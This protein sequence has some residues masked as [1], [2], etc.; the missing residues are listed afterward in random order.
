MD[1]E[2]LG[3]AHVVGA[4]DPVDEL[5][6]GQHASGVAQQHLQEVEL[7]ERQVDLAAGD[8][9]HVPVD[10]HPHRAGLQGLRYG[11]L[12]FAPAAQHGADAGDQLA[13]GEGL[14][15]VVVGPYLQPDDLVD[16]AVL[17]GDHDHRHV[18]A[19]AQL[20]ADLGAGESGQHQV[21][22]DQVGAVALELVEP[23]GPGG[24]DGDLEALLAEHV[25][26]SVAEGFLILDDEH[27]GHGRT[28]GAGRTDG[29]A[30]SGT[31]TSSV[32]RAAVAPEASG[33]PVSGR[34]RVFGFVRRSRVAPASGR[35]RVKVEPGPRSSRR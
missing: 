23:L 9:D 19:A 26:Q 35:R 15:D 8:G 14:G 27:S 4:P 2:G 18:G 13:R 12:R 34:G 6:P 1:V 30:E 7:L 29:G 22:Q 17:G 10:V 3:V 28:S 33:P 31:G 32:V 20:A 5:H 21:E 11:L 25:G 24:R 16:L